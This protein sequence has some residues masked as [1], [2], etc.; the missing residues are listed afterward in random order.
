MANIRFGLP[1][2]RNIVVTAEMAEFVAEPHEVAVTDVSKPV[3]VLFDLKILPP[4]KISRKHSTRNASPAV[5]R[6]TA[7][8]GDTPADAAPNAA[9]PLTPSPIEDL[10]APPAEMVMPGM[11]ADA[12]TESVAVSG[13]NA[14]ATFNGMFDPQRLADFQGLGGPGGPG[15]GPG[16]P[17]HKELVVVAVV[18]AEVAVVD[19]AAEVVE[20]A[21]RF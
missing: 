4:S 5:R 15:G 10:S 14:Q 18:G 6:Q 2:R 21:V 12:P 7:A 9:E 8:A 3:D 19:A 13:N 1:G 11:S 16:G 20:V 17:G